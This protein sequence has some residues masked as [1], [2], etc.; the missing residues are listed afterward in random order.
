[1]SATTEEL[2]D[3]LF[4]D[5]NFI[6]KATRFASDAACQVVYVTKE[7]FSDVE[8]DGKLIA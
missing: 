5:P 7:T 3:S 4:E 1:M 6:E 8:E 2:E